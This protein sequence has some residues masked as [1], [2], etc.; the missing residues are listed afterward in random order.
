MV[1]QFLGPMLGSIA[2]AAGTA[3]QLAGPIGSIM[4]IFS[5]MGGGGNA[6]PPPMSEQ[7]RYSIKLLKALAQPNNS[8]VKQ[9]QEEEFRNLRSGVLSDINE[10]VLA[11][12]REGLMGRSPVFFDP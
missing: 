3:G 8:Y 10:K 1:L 12:R 5:G 6:G 7:E 9:M 2:G 11:D 4:S